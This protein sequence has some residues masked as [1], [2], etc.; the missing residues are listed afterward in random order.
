M[1]TGDVWVTQIPPWGPQCPFPTW[2]QPG[3]QCRG[4]GG[5]SAGGWWWP[6]HHCR[7][8]SCR[9]TC[10]GTRGVKRT[11]GA[12]C[13]CHLP[14]TCLHLKKKMMSGR[15]GWP[16]GKSSGGDTMPSS[17]ELVVT[18]VGREG[19]LQSHW[20]VSQ[21][22]GT[23]SHQSVPVLLVS[24]SHQ[25]VQ[26]LLGC[27]KSHQG[28]PV[29]LRSPRPTGVSQ[30]HHCVPFPLQC[31]PIPPRHISDNVPIPNKVPL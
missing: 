18:P 6:G 30:Y 4:A 2:G 14:V 7:A 8:V 5:H 29:P 3:C 1:T 16:G 25:R 9:W 13:G 10:Q 15:S 21:Y 31:I 19:C 22:P 20:G 11:V 24:Q 26:V 23:Q 17:T 27:L 12:L 28:V